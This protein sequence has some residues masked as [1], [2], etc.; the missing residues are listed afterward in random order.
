MQDGLRRGLIG[1]KPGLSDSDIFLIKLDA[2]RI[3]AFQGGGYEVRTARSSY[4]A[5][6]AGEA[7][8]FASLRA[9]SRLA[10]E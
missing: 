2:N 9:L 10:Q 4:L 5:P 3:E 8:V 6:G 1:R 7:M